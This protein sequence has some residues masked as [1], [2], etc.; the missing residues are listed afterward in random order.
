MKIFVTG[1]SG[2]VGFAVAC[3]LRRAG[4]EVY[5]MVRRKEAETL[6]RR[7]EIHPVTATMQNPAAAQ[8]TVEQCA[9]LIH[10][11]ADYQTDTMKTDR[12]MVAVLLATA[13][14]SLQHKTVIY[15][16]GV[17]VHGDTGGEL[18]DET[19]VLHPA[20]LVKDRPEIERLVLE[21]PGIRGLVVRPGCVYGGRGGLTGAWFS[22]AE[23]GEVNIVGNGDNRWAM[24]HVEDLA[25]AYLQLAE[26]GLKGEVFDITDR[27]R[28]TVNE[29]A[30]AAVIAAGGKAKFKHIP[31]A[32]AQ[33]GMGD[34][35]ACLALD[36]HVDARKAVR[37]LGWQPKHGG[38]V[39]SAEIYYQAWKA[40]K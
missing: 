1:A 14:R 28:A 7:A 24:V 10:A 32:E 38:F 34:F 30:A 26:S 12:Q 36:Q 11:A 3:A 6:L 4:H 35:A 29:M 2:Y 5:G 20:Q 13:R 15:T 27:S 31:L 33:Q 39:D 21:S 8:A 19:T 40:W 16:S 37:L 17:W 23:S 18:V 25:D 22:G 9:V